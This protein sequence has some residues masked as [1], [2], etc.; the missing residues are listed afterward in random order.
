MVVKKY[1]LS[2]IKK[3][4]QLYNSSPTV[5]ATYY[6]KLAIIELCG[7]I[8]FSMDNIVEYF[9]NKHIKTQPL[10]DSFK[11]LKDNNNGFDYK[12]NFRK[13]LSQTIGMHN[14]EK[15]ELSINRT[16]NVNIL[17]ATLNNLK[18]LRNDAAHTYID[19]TKTYQAP[20]V[21]KSQLELIYPILKDFS[22]EIKK[23]K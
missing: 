15:L 7:W 1:I 3:L 23:I 17:D 22:T 19:T 5:E 13:M 21:T 4:D 2:N 10:K 12:H 6:S 11:S 14:M 9:A 18:N 20:S 16:G 8:E